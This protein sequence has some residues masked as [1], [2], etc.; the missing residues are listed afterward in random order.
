MSAWSGQG[1]PRVPGLAG[2]TD[3][4]Q[5]QTEALTQLPRTLLDLNRAV[6]ELVEMVSAARD[7]VASTQRVSARLE[8]VVEELEEPVRALK[9]GLERVARVLND[10]TI[11]T[12]PASLRAIQDDVLPL[13]HGL[14]E[15][16]AKIDVIATKAGE[17]TTRLVELP[18]LSRLLRARPGKADSSAAAPPESPSP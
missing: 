17:A 14:R 8:A 2:L 1:L 9:P 4:L 18:G 10:P 12:V 7:T 3:Q 13:I 6:A 16:Q 5:A 11:D 15:T